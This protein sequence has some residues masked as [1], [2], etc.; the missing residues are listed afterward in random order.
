L[1]T[2]PYLNAWPLL[3]GLAECDDVD[4]TAEPPSRLARSLRRRQYD[5][6]LVPVVELL[7]NPRL[8]V[9]SSAC[10]GSLGPVLS[11]LLFLKRSPWRLATVAL[12]PHSA[13]SQMLTRVILAERYG[14]RPDAFESHPERGLAD[15]RADAVLAIGDLAL[16][17]RL[18][19]RPVLDLASEWFALTGLPFVFAVWAA[20]EEVLTRRPDL[21]ARLDAARDAGER[22]REALVAR[23]APELGVPPE[24]S[25]VYLNRAIR[26]RLAAPERAG[27]D[28]FL[29]LARPFVEAA[30]AL[31]H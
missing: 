17:L 6:A 20:D 27:L 14:L 23:A 24:V 31:S 30:D 7:R 4:V 19:E 21:A 9:V 15:P 16:K 5:A 29:E 3:H 13:T 1:G 25:R 11:V 12:D 2:V 26:Y 10:V 18:T 8:R 22:D 28:R